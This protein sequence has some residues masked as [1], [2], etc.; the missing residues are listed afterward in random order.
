MKRLIIILISVLAAVSCTKEIDFDGGVKEN[1]LVAYA[2]LEEGEPLNLSLSSTAPSLGTASIVK[3]EGYYGGM[4]SPAAVVTAFV[5]NEKYTLLPYRDSIYRN[6]YCPKA[7]E[8][9]R[10]EISYPGYKAVNGSTTIPSQVDAE[11]ISASLDTINNMWEV[12]VRIHD[13]P[14][15]D[16][17]RVQIYD[18]FIGEQIFYYYDDDWKLIDKKLE[19]YTD[20]Q[21]KWMNSKDAVF[22]SAQAATGIIEEIFGED[23]DISG[24]FS[25]D[26]FEGKDYDITLKAP[27]YSWNYEKERAIP[28][29]NG[30]WF[31]CTPYIMV[32][33]VSRELYIYGSSYWAYQAVGDDSIFSDP[34]QIISNV[35]EGT[36][37]IGALSRLNIPLK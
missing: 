6:D 14:G 23:A 34:V 1:L 18:K 36:G 24:F 37:C 21:S 10:F 20:N 11:L 2:E 13:K 33:A 30:E 26:L 31:I 32:Q 12:K 35:N 8:T 25:D 19:H 17:Y 5:G 16:F 27:G 3:P 22:G 28:N 4:F 7:G 15:A 29:E 9:I